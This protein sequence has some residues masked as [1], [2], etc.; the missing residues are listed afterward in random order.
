MPLTKPP[1][2]PPKPTFDEFSTPDD[3]NAQFKKERNNKVY[4]SMCR[5]RKTIHEMFRR[6]QLRQVQMRIFLSSISGVQ[7]ELGKKENKTAKTWY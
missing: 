3:F 4:E 7:E 1:P 6:Q 2:P 5:R